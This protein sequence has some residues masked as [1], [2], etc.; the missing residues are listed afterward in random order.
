MAPCLV[1]PSILLR[2][3]RKAADSFEHYVGQ[4]VAKDNVAALMWVILASRGAGGGGQ[5][6]SQKVFAQFRQ[7]LSGEMPSEQIAEAE[8]QAR[9]W[10]PKSEQESKGPAGK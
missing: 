10:R 5:S 2:W 6:E 3:Y 9:E 8:R 1:R 7:K 4:K